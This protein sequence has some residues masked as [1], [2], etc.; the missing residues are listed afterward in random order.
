MPDVTPPPRSVKGRPGGLPHRISRPEVFQEHHVLRLAPVLDHDA[1]G[2]RIGADKK[3][4]LSHLAVVDQRRRLGGVPAELAPSL[5]QNGSI[6][7][8]VL[9]GCG[10]AG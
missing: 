5:H 4:V 1:L 8:D 6:G 2:R 9:D 7:G 3:F 10:A